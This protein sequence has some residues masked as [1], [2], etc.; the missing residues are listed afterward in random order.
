M[1]L[2]P[3][4]RVQDTDMDMQKKIIIFI[5]G[6]LIVGVLATGVYYLIRDDIGMSADLQQDA[7]ATA[8]AVETTRETQKTA[9]P[10][11]ITPLQGEGP[12]Y[13]AGSP[14]RTDLRETSTAGTPLTITG[15]VY[16]PDCQPVAGAWLD[17]WQAD[18]TGAYDMEGFG[19]RGQQYTDEE[20]RYRLDTIIPDEYPGRPAHIHVKFRLPGGTVY[21]SQ[22]FFSTVPNTTDEYLNP[23]L[24]MNLRADGEG[25]VADHDF[26]LRY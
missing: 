25:F 11:A 17:F 15:I 9:C 23:A 19:L 5:G 20:G 13:L 14:E 1:G 2:D 6:L 24:I 3:R 7:D 10:E 8:D 18:A 26:R 22:L 16:D 21:P 4:P 12:Y